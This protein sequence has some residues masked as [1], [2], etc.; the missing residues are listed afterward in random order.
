V[1]ALKLEWDDRPE[2][3]H[4]VAPPEGFDA[5]GYVAV[6]ATDDAKSRLGALRRD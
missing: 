3:V 5:A 2:P 1:R 4:E 6:G